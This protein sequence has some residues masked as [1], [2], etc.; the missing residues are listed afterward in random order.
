MLKRLVLGFGF[1][2]WVLNRYEQAALI[3]AF[4]VGVHPLLKR[5]L[6]VDSVAVMPTLI[7][8]YVEYALIGTRSKYL[9]ACRRRGC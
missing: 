4:H 3:A 8:R 5:F 6:W 7:S 2:C 1:P 9:L